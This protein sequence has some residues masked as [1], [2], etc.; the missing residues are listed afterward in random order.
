MGVGASA[1]EAAANGESVLLTVQVIPAL[2]PTSSGLAVS[3][4]LS[5]IGGEAG[6]DFYDDGTHGDNAAGDL[7]FTFQ[8]MVSMD[9]PA[10]IKSL[11]VTIRDAQ[12]RPG[13]TA[14]PLEVVEGCG[15]AYTKI[16]AIQGSG[17]VSPMAGAV[18]ETEGVVVGDFQDPGQLNGFFFQDP[19]GDG[20]PQT[21]DGIFVYQPGGSAASA[22]ERVRVRG[23]VQ[24]YKGLTEI[25]QVVRLRGCGVGTVAATAI[26]LPEAIDGDLERYE[27][28]LVTTAQPLTVS[29]TYWLGEYGQVTLSANGRMYNPTNGQGGTTG[30]NARRRLV[31]DDGSSTAYPNPLPYLG[32]DETL[33]DGDTVSGLVGVLDEG[34]AGTGQD[35]RLQPVGT[36]TFTRSNPRTSAPVEMDG[37]LKVASF[38]LDNYFTTPGSRGAGTPEEFIRQRTKII[39]ALKAINADIVGLVEVENN[40]AAVADLVSGLNQAT[41]P[42]KYAAILEPAPGT[43]LIKVALIYQPGRVSTVG[44]AQNYQTSTAEYA[45]LF[46]RPPLS[47]TFILLSNGQRLTVVLNH[48]KSKS[49]GSASGPDADL[50][51]G[52]WNAK[53]TQQAQALLTFANS[54]RASGGDADVLVIGDL[55]SYGEEDPVQAL[56]RGGLWSEAAGRIGL[57]DRYSYT[58]DG[59]AGYLDHALA[60]PSLHAQVIGAAFWHINADEP[61]ALDYHNPD[62]SQPD[63]YRS[64]DHDPLVVEMKLNPGVY[65]PVVKR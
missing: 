10:G 42:G 16:P 7:V 54:L 60:T 40:A 15:A 18:V 30:L 45:P 53:R 28:M 21:A 64:S 11:G 12:G 44:A 26:T 17:T 2:D 1:P 48:F 39:A 14:I 31:L 51:Q 58:F 50:G 29:D 55:N 13:S 57:V 34:P 38:N 43:D 49:C 52:C 36:V 8:G 47:Q 65:L 4:D 6:Q 25:A 35:Y 41:Q 32:I 59:L 20:S 56:V 9:A 22:G 37:N 3:A 61:Q 62:L 24:E 19:A 5:G 33:R 46:E 23:T 63:A 27:G